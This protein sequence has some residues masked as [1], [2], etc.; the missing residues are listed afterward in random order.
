MKLCCIF[1]VVDGSVFI[2]TT[3]TLLD[4]FFLYEVNVATSTNIHFGVIAIV[5]H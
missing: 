5:D 3:C 4:A 1:S 2:L